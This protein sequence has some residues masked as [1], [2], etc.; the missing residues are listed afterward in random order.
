[1]VIG[2]HLKMKMSKE[3]FVRAGSAT[4]SQRQSFDRSSNWVFAEA[5]ID[6]DVD[7]D[8]VDVHDDAMAVCSRDNCENERVRRMKLMIK[9]VLR[10]RH[11]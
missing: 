11:K 8:V 10:C 5:D 6:M 1:M 7:M 9:E 4:A 2:L 3:A